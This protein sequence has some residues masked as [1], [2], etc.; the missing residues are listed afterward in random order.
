M[1]KGT[2]HTKISKEKLSLTHLA[3]AKRGRS[4]HLWKGGRIKHSK[5]Y[6]LVSVPHHPFANHDGYVPEH[7]VVVEKQIGRFLEPR[8]E[9]VHHVDEDITNNDLKNLMVVSHKHHRRIHNGWKLIKSRWL[10]PCS[11]CGKLLELS[12]FYQRKSGEFISRC[13]PCSIEIRRRWCRK[14]SVLGAKNL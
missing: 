13:K 4:H 2:H 11:N 3:I 12:Q 5:G 9:Q 1:L 8:I 10:K 14:Q 7:R 6:W